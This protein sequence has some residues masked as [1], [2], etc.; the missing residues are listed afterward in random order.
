MKTI[1]EIKKIGKGDRYYIYLDDEFFGIYEAE[2]LARHGFKSGQSFDDDFFENLKIENGDYACFNRGLSLLEK[3]MKTQKMLKDYLREKGYPNSCIEKAIEKL[4]EY[5][6]IND[7]SFCENFIISYKNSKSK[8]KLR[9]DLLSKG[10]KEDIIEK[11]LTELLD[12]EDER[13]KCLNLARKYMKNREF[14]LKTKQKFY[15][16]LAGKGFDFGNIGY[17]WES[18]ENGRN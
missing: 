15:N 6:Y 14:D 18:L 12:E 17:A 13:E 16:H 5:G 8:R 2:I 9:Y 4:S 11:K 3:S 1:T 10:V 7:E